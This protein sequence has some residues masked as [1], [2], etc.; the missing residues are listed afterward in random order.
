MQCPQCGFYGQPGAQY[1]NQCGGNFQQSQAAASPPARISKFVWV[2]L[3]I[4]GLLALGFMVGIFAWMSRGPSRA[5]VMMTTVSG[6]IKA[7]A[8]APVAFSSAPSSPTNVEAQKRLA[9][10]PSEIASRER[11]RLKEY[12]RSTI[13]AARPQL[14]YIG[15]EITEMNSG[16]ALWA[17]HE[18][19]SRDS[20]SRGDDA[21]I[22]SAWMAQNR[23]ELQKAN[24]VRVGLMGRGPSSSFCW[25]ELK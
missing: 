23:I 15:S 2:G 22:V 5:R 7:E 24:I 12:F 21:K 14:N 16:Y 3:T 20:F 9:E 25:L 11:Q 6:S 8:G 19:F 10:N 1:C 17:I 13:A 18:V 4:I